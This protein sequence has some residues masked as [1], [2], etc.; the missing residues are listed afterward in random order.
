[1]QPHMTFPT[2]QAHCRHNMRG[3][4]RVFQLIKSDY[5]QL[6]DKDNNKNKTIQKTPITIWKVQQ[7]HVNS[8]NQMSERFF[9]RPTKEKINH[10][11]AQARAFF[12]HS[13]AARLLHN[14]S[15]YHS[16]SNV[17]YI[18]LTKSYQIYCKK[19]LMLLVGCFCI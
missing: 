2:P 12:L 19:N 7:Q 18:Y 9:T 3:S 6:K 4:A 11:S 8:K 16:I 13:S 5:G 14:Y 1:M 17:W 10:H 15:K